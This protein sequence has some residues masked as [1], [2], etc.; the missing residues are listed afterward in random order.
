MQKPIS[1]AFLSYAREDA[2]FVLSL[3]KDLRTA[4]AGVWIDQL[5]IA[6][7]QRWDRAV[8]DALAKCLEL[9]VVLSPASVESTNVMDEVSLALEDGKTVVPVIHRQCKV[10]FRLRRLQYVDLS[11][12]YSAGLDRLL[13]TLGVGLRPPPNVGTT[14]PGTADT[15][16]VNVKRGWFVDHDMPPVS[17]KT[18]ELSHP[19]SLHFWF[20]VK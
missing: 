8:E 9:V 18:P 12:N 16:R 10:P 20:R 6:P 15:P 4:G 13:E 3:A 19:A 1:F 2:E 17:D 14:F 11:L 7:G 5:D